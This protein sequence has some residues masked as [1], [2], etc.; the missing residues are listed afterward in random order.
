MKKIK[1]YIIVIIIIY[2]GSYSI[3]YLRRPKGATINGFYFSYTSPSVSENVEIGLYWF[4]YPVYKTHLFM[5]GQ[6][7]TY[8]RSHYVDSPNA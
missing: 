4:Y 7:H 1:W 3:L 8:D 6:K 2:I 5:G